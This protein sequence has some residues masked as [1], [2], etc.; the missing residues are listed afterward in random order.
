MNPNTKKRPPPTKPTRA[1]GYVRSSK[2]RDDETSTE[3]QAERIRAHCK[4]QDLT[5]VEVI[6][7]PGRSAYTSSRTSRKKFRE[8]MGLITSGAADVLVVWKLDRA[9]RNA[10]DTLNLVTELADHDAQLVSVTEHFD[11]S[12]ASGK[13]TLTVLAALA[14]MESA[15]KSERMEV[16]Q[17]KRLADLAVPTGP[18]PFGYR[19]IPSKPGKPGTLRV[20][21][22]EAAVVRDA[23]KRL[24]AREGLKAIVDN[25]TA[26]GV[27]G[28]H[29]KPITRRGLRLILLSPTIAA[30]RESSPG[31]FVR[32]PAW[33]PIL[34]REQ[35]DAVRAVLLDPARRTTTSPHRRW[36]LSGTATCGRCQVPMSCKQDRRVGARYSCRSA[37]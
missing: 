21:R 17:A 32:S 14:E 27:N 37:I 5:V 18:R 19:R 22:A 30:C 1:V 12:A 28:T 10:V 7:D 23:A 11:T 33:E 15:T 35:W 6:I 31:V 29:D 24:L 16:W 34:T 9:C 3:T 8:A 4:A 25:L 36:L 26:R 13:L 2:D 20:N